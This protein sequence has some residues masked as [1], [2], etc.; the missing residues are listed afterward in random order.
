MAEPRD[1]QK[2]SEFC[3][4]VEATHLLEYLGVPADATS[5]E[6][7]EALKK[8][9]TRMQSM[10]S[11]PK[12]KTVAMALIK[13]FRALDRVLDDPNAH[14]QQARLEKEAQQLP[15]LEIA[16]DAVLA[17]G[18]LT[19]AEVD[20]VREQAMK[21]G[22][23]EARYDQVLREKSKA[24]GVP[25]PGGEAGAGAPPAWAGGPTFSSEDDSGAPAGAVTA[26]ERRKLK[27]AAGHGWWDAAFTSLLLGTIPGGPGD[28]VDIYC[29]TALSAVTLLPERRQL[30]YL[31]V[32]RNP[33]RVQASW[34]AAR[35]FGSRAKF[36]VGE[37][38][39]LPLEDQSVD[40]VLGIRALANLPDT[41]TVFNDAYRV[42]RPGGRMIVAEPDGLAEVFMFDG[43]LWEYN[44][45][46]HRLTRRID[47]LAGGPG[48][49]AGSIG[50][51]G[52]ALGPKLAQRMTLAGL[53]VSQIKV[54]ASN[55]LRPRRFGKLAKMLRRYPLAMARA[56]GLEDGSDELMAIE[57]AVRRLEERW[58]ADAVGMGGHVLPMVLVV[59][60]KET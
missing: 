43:H 59:A 41:A 60:T 48:M 27:G 52:I 13:N 53:T 35:Q 31:G 46:F 10:Q 1:L 39:Q 58:S 36:E 17:S 56:Q 6:A 19:E 40:Y 22:I 47:D 7:K 37:P 12:Y 15:T 25:L 45:A 38:H 14:L 49:M 4:L 23:S 29:R 9:R 5:D 30:S 44:H 2:A 16:V 42:L 18:T 26:E 8:M 28:M 20:Y 50:K 32:D 54:H 51:P 55:N 24:A 57:T 21:L 33:E 34:E 3:K 11:N